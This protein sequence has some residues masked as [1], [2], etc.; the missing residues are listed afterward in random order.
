MS[1]GTGGYGTTEYGF[2]GHFDVDVSDTTVVTLEAILAD[3]GTP[4]PSAGSVLAPP[5]QPPLAPTQKRAVLNA[6]DHVL[7]ITPLLRRR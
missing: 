7:R 2:I 4:T 5:R 3:G 6:P 1:Y